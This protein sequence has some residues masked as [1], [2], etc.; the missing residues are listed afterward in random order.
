MR[1]IQK[2][3]SLVAV[4]LALNF[5]AMAIAGVMVAQRAGLDRQ[6]IGQIREILFPPEVSATKEVQEPAETSEPTPM[7]QLIAL[8]DAQT[9]KPTEQRVQDIQHTFDQRTVDLA[10]MRRELSDLRNQIEIASRRLLDER[11][12]F[13]TERDV[14]QDAVDSARR[15]AQEEGFADALAL[16]TQLPSKQTKDL[17]LQLDEETVLRYLRA[18]D[19][20]AAAK[21]LRE[22][23]SEPETTKAAAILELMRQGN[24]AAT[25]A[26]QQ[27]QQAQVPADG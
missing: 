21:V 17:F 18:M 7:E 20:T 9:G 5:V 26:A 23:K 3:L 24:I 11:Q 8:L 27:D 12:A 14:W 6:K 22:F 10:R 2:L 25:A 16:Y 15:L 19:V 4:V 1:G 13:M